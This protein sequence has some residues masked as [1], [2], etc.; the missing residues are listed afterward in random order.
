MSLPS[1]P[2]PSAP[3]LPLTPEEELKQ[4][5]EQAALELRIAWSKP[6]Y[7]QEKEAQRVSHGAKAV[8]KS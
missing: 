5:L 6:G 3:P 1:L 2:K 7:W 8:K 4:N